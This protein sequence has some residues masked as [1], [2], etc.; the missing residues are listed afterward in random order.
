MAVA[1]REY[2][3]LLVRTLCVANLPTT[4]GVQERVMQ[5]RM[6]IMRKHSKTRVEEV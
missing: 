5:Q 6:A 3:M 4:A 1:D 2:C